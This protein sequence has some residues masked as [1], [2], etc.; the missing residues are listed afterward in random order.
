LCANPCITNPNVNFVA[1]TICNGESIFLEG[2]NQ[3]TAGLY[4]DVFPAANGCDSTIYTTITVIE[5]VTFDQTFTICQGSSINVGTSTYSSS[6]IYT[7]V[8]NAANGCDSTVTTTLFVS[9]T[10][11]SNSSATICQG[12]SY[13]FGTTSLTVEGTYTEILGALGGCDSIV[14]LFLTVLPIDTSNVF[15]SICN[16]QSYTFGSTVLTTSGTY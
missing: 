2:A 4:T 8:L 6:G 7:D 15:V 13:L 1:T 11:T 12:D 10:L 16:G 3:T 5:P 14:T 9:S